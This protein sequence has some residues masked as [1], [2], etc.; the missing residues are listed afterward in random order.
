MG[1][2]VRK[3]GKK[4]GV[5]INHK[6]KR[7]ALIRWDNRREAE[8]AAA[9][10]RRDLALTS[11]GLA[12]EGQQAVPFDKY[13]REWLRAHSLRGLAP[14]TILGQYKPAIENHAIPYFGSRDVRTIETQ[15]VRAF[16]TLLRERGLADK[17]IAG[18]LTPLRMVFNEAL[19]EGLVDRNPV[20]VAWKKERRRV[21][22]RKTFET[23]TSV[24]LERLLNVI[25]EQYPDYYAFFYTLAH[26]GMRLGEARG[27]RW[28]D[29]AFG[30]SPEDC[31]R[32]IYIRQTIGPSDKP[33]PTKTGKA[34]RVDLSRQLREVL[35]AHQ[36]QEITSGR[37]KPE[38]LAFCRPD[39]K[40]LRYSRLFEVFK[41]SLQLA[42][43]QDMRM[44]DL[45]HSFAVIHL[46]ELR[47]PLVWVS[48]QLGHRSIELTVSVYGH[49]EL[50]T[51]PT[52]ADRF[53]AVEN[54]PIRATF[55]NPSAT[56]KK[57][58]PETPWVSG[59]LMVGDA[60]F[61]PATSR[62]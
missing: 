32:H 29:V 28:G 49:P 24:E 15:D 14:K 48:A 27:L 39:G 55:R 30:Q 45:R 41:R 53:G 33:Q 59:N 57:K 31:H 52:L 19:E 1:V 8:A 17:T 42:G 23:L 40:T 6:G 20:T 13:A 3:K 26:T 61:E 16:I 25:G 7:K 56:E 35:L 10:I 36:V 5:F 34:R 12:T 2:R 51:D 62:V 18:N 37:G 47:N 54:T 44:H 4:W 21:K 22:E 43:L 38:Q 9:R 50:D 11:L 46:R 60:G 58:K